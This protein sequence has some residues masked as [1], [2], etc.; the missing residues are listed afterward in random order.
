MIDLDAAIRIRVEEQLDMVVQ[1][2]LK[3]NGHFRDVDI[4]RIAVKVGISN[5]KGELS[6]TKSL[7]VINGEKSG[8]PTDGTACANGRRNVPGIILVP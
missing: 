8:R 7:P 1:A 2:H 6:A 3:T 5:G 4:A